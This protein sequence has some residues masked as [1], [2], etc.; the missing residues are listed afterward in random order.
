MFQRFR[1]NLKMSVLLAV[2]FPCFV[3]LL[4]AVPDLP[5]KNEGLW[6]RFSWKS[7][8][9]H[10]IIWIMIRAFHSSSIKFQEMHS[11]LVLFFLSLKM[12]G[13]CVYIYIIWL[14]MCV[15][16]SILLDP[17]F[18]DQ[19]TERQRTV[20]GRWKTSWPRC[21]SVLRA[22]GSQSS[23]DSPAARHRGFSW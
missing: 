11:T 2:W 9:D 12:H 6:N 4:W 14:Y 10:E 7:M 3:T 5:N 8:N 20:P 1:K 15:I 19:Q 23:P 21:W 18:P 16:T 17:F 22:P 13:V